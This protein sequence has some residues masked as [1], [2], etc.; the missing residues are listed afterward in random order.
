[1]N[2][3]YFGES[4]LAMGGWINRGQTIF[5]LGR[6]CLMGAGAIALEYLMAFS[7][8]GSEIFSATHLFT[9][10]VVDAGPETLT[11]VLWVLFFAWLVH[12]VAF[13]AI[14]WKKHK[15]SLDGDEVALSLFE[16]INHT[17]VREE[18]EA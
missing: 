9:G 7:F 12:V 11:K 2:I 3:P 4:I 14:G 16:D 13:F 15:K 18:G 6:V 10:K 8:D 1:M 17:I 5:Y